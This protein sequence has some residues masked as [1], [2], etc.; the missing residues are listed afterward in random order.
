MRHAAAALFLALT[1][2]GCGVKSLF[3]TAVSL[4]VLGTQVA[5]ASEQM[6][7]ACEQRLV[8]VKLCNQYAEAGAKFKK[9]YPIAVGLWTAAADAQDTDTQSAADKVVRKLA[10]DLTRIATEALGQFLQEDK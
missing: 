10:A 7:R 1:L 4:E 3:V 2:A 5:A 9:S 6:T 8:T